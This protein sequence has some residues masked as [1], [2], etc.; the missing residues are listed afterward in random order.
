[1]I[2]L[3]FMNRIYPNMSSGDYRFDKVKKNYFTL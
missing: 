2:L 1:M 3:N